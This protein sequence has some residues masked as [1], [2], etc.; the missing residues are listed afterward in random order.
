VQDIDQDGSD[1]VLTVD[2]YNGFLDRHS[3][4]GSAFGIETIVDMPWRIIV[5]GAD[6]KRAGGGAGWLYYGQE[7]QWVRLSQLDLAVPDATAMAV[8]TLARP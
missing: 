8:A 1:D 6:R 2:A 3:S 4:S 7:F 5:G